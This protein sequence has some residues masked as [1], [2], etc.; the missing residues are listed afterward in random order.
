MCHS[1]TRLRPQTTRRAAPPLKPPG[2]SLPGRWGESRSGLGHG[3][4]WPGLDLP[5][6]GS[7]LLFRVCCCCYWRRRGDGVGWGPG[8][9]CRRRHRCPDSLAFR[10][11]LPPVP[12]P[13][14]PSPPPPSP[15]AQAPPSAPRPPR[16][17]GSP[18]VSVP[19]QALWAGRSCRLLPTSAFR[20]AGPRSLMYLK[21]PRCLL[22]APQKASRVP[23]R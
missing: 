20:P 14:P 12:P 6:S 2:P 7:C 19:C 11:R 1:R 4:F 21:G 23:T 5:L 16:W 22:P 3:S 10:V 15:F 13:R 8:Q 17:P 18:S 9:S